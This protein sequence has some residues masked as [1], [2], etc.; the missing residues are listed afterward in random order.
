MPEIVIYTTAFC[1]YCFGAKHLLASKG[2]EWE[3]IDLLEQPHRRQ[4]M[5][6]RA[7]GRHTVPQ[8]FVN[9]QGV[10]GFDEIAALDRRGKL[11]DLLGLNGKAHD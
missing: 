11:D 8:I 2:V 10:G 5:L 1:P 7:D 9:G 3:E 4:E 6:E